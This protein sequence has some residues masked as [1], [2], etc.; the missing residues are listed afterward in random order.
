[1]KLLKGAPWS[2]RDDAADRGTAIHAAVEA[3]LGDRPLPDG[4][5]EEEFDCAVAVEAFL[6]Q[7]VAKV[8]AVELTVH[9][10]PR[11]QGDPPPAS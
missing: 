5:T 7:H 1:M 2:Q 6:R 3:Y 9:G 11:R 10:E 8:L 4:L